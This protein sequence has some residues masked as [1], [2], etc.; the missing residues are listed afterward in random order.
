MEMPTLWL[1]LVAQDF[2]FFLFR[3]DDPGDYTSHDH[4]PMVT[5]LVRE[6]QFRHQAETNEV[7]S[8]HIP[9]V[10]VVDLVDYYHEWGRRFTVQSVI[11]LQVVHDPFFGDLPTAEIQTDQCEEYAKRAQRETNSPP[12]SQLVGLLASHIHIVCDKT[13]SSDP[14]TS[15][16]RYRAV[17]I[18]QLA[19][20]SRTSL[21]RSRYPRSLVQPICSNSQPLTR[22]KFAAKVA[23]IRP[24]ST[25]VEISL[26]LSLE[27]LFLLYQLDTL[28]CH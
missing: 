15:N 21:S 28:R 14:E 13:P 4:G 24:R 23:E 20:G 7:A 18:T 5:A 2:K 27:F 9:I 17:Q 12:S 25:D 16:S 6:R 10:G 3:D 1:L 19:T 22:L 11:F 8:S 26:R